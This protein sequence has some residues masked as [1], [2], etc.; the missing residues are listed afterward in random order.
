MKIRSI[1]IVAGLFTL[2][3][4]FAG[5]NQADDTTITINGHTPGVTPFISN[6]SLTASNT[7]VLKSIQFTIA[8]KPGSVTRPLSG[9]YANYYLMN[10][11]FENPQTGEIT[12][13][14]Y[15]LYAGRANTVT[16]TYRFKD[17]SSKQAHTTITT[18]TFDDLCGYNNATLL[19]PRT[20][21]TDLSYDYI[22]ISN[23]GCA[24]N[25]PVIIDTDRRGSLG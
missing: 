11:G 20:D 12:L 9:T 23:G 8:P 17:G 2:F 22:F 24:G 1:T 18:A 10:R 25:S 3:V 19:Q 15:G 5:S 21:S 7:T 13:P 4:P 6:V 14:V 16:L